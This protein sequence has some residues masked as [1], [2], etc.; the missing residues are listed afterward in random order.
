MTASFRPAALSVTLGLVAGFVFALA[1]HPACSSNTPDQGQGDGGDGGP[2]DGGDGG[3]NDSGNG[4]A[5]CTRDAECGTA[6]WCE[7]STGA[8]RDAKP[9]P[10]GQGNCD[11]QPGLPDYCDNSRCFCDPADSS[12]KPLHLPCA[13]CTKTA[14]CGDDP[15]A[16]VIA[17]CVPASAG[18]NTIDSCIPRK[19]ATHGCPQGFTQPTDGGVLCTPAGG[20]CGA[21]GLCNSDQECDPH[22]PTPICDTGR[23]VCIAACTF[24]LKTG[25]SLCPTGQVCHMIPGLKDLPPQD[26]NFGKGH[27]APPCAPGV[28][29]CGQG[30]T[31]AESGFDKKVLRCRLPPP[32][33]MGDIECPESPSTNSHGYCDLAAH[34]CKS[35]CRTKDDCKAG[36]VCTGS[37]GN[38]ACVAETCL[39]AGGAALG[40]E[41]GQFCCG[42]TGAP[43]CP[44][45]TANGACFDHA[46]QT[47]CGT[48]A[49]NSDCRTSAFPS[50]N[51]SPNLCVE[52]ANSSK[53]C[54]VGCTAGGPSGQCPRSWA[55]REVDVGCDAASD[56]G[57][58]AGAT[59][60]KP[61]GGS[62]TCT[63][64]STAD[65]PTQ[66]GGASE[67]T[68][69]TAGK[70]VVTHVCA[71][72]CR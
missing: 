27:C 41:Y 56:C 17:E 48:C 40:C 13:A 64:T 61:D 16:D 9:C 50:V 31:C 15:F 43:A 11:Y 52:L 53:V 55:C 58:Q 20:A 46:G 24:D 59:C 68:V 69:C 47:W 33:C 3:Q 39:Q 34:S 1:L 22:S 2:G 62:G 38:R 49:D 70:C 12:C 63:C 72:G 29:A 65:C 67:D 42:E 44:S 30:L 32:E 71:P 60:N 35:D 66:A 45:G 7:L 23:K 19:D 5:A 10:S 37:A 28:T 51:G 54:A 25:D 26:P 18:Y 6:R 8:C 4:P 14:E 36:T 57:N 21:A